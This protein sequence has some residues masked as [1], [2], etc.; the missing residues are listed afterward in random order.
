MLS[1]AL[2]LLLFTQLLTTANLTTQVTR[3]SATGLL[4][5]VLFT[6]FLLLVWYVRVDGPLALVFGLGAGVV[7]ALY[8]TIVYRVKDTFVKAAAA[9]TGLIYFLAALALL[10]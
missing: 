7:S 9:V 4:L 3:T 1:I 5:Q 8:A 2:F 6:F 10:F